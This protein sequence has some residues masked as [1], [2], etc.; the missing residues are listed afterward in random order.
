MQIPPA[1]PG[2][3][4]IELRRKNG[5]SLWAWVDEADY[6]DVSRFHWYATVGGPYVARNV[7]REDGTRTIEYLHRRLIPGAERVDH[8]DGDGLNNTR[9]NLRATTHAENMRNRRGPA[10]HGTSG[11]LGVSWQKD[12]GKWQAYLRDDAGKRHVGQFASPV[13]AAIARDCACLAVDPEHFTLNF[14]ELRDLVA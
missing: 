2:A 13:A 14:P 12:R 6:E 5:P 3:R 4:A 9:A 7:R 8:R 11:F 10:A 1:P